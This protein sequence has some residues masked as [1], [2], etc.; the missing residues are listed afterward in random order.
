VIPF[1]EKN[2]N[3]KLLRAPKV[4]K[5]VHQSESLVIL[6]LMIKATSPFILEI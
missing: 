4:W 1:K 2:T 6:N 3:A 5:G